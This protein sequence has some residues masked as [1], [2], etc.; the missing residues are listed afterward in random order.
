MNCINLI[1]CLGL[2]LFLCK[3]TGL[4]QIIF[5]LVN[6]VNILFQKNVTY[7]FLIFNPFHIFECFFSHTCVRNSDE[8]KDIQ[9]VVSAYSV[10]EKQ[11]ELLFCRI[12]SPEK[13]NF[14]DFRSNT[15]I[16]SVLSSR[17]FLFAILSVLT[18]FSY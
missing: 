1:K 12:R 17:V 8:I 5:P 16:S 10:L 13:S 4:N 2:N 18:L 11:T 14:Q 6:A 7:Y 9:N 15:A 3:K